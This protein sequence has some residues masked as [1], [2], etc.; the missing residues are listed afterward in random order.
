M[1]IVRVL[2]LVAAGC[3]ALGCGVSAYEQEKARL[4]GIE[5][6]ENEQAMRD[7]PKAGIT[8]DMPRAERERRVIEDDHR[9]AMEA[10]KGIEDLKLPKLSDH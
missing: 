9:Q 1:A 5:R 4:S 7:N 6:A 10:V 8:P 2:V 3:L